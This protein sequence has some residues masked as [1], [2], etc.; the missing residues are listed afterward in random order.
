VRQ[1]IFFAAMV[2]ASLLGQAAEEGFATQR[3][4]EEIAKL[5]ELAA[6]GAV[7][8]ARLAQAE[9]MLADAQDEDTLQRLL[10]GQVRV[11]NLSQEQAREVVAA[12]A[13]RVDR[14]AARYRAQLALAEQGVIPK[15]Q[16]EEMEQQLADRRLTLQL[17]EGRAR[18]FADLM[19]M[20]KV[21]EE[22]AVNQEAD[23][24]PPPLIERFTGSGVFRNT[25]LDSV[26]A[27]FEKQFGRPLPV[28]ARGQSA[29]HTLLGFD[30][31]GR[32]DVALN[33]DEPEGQWLRQQLQALQVPYLALRAKIPGS[34]TAPH[35]HIGLPSQRVRAADTALGSG[36]N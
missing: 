7:S 13:R 3:A 27:G 26:A 20:A 17:A 21:E 25:H 16:V 1:S 23:I 10:Y 9:E 34:S 4:R 6:M 32:V 24:E 15:G 11:E 14:V 5:R 31:T 12:A 33:P 29:M 36:L 22:F 8:R 35:I 30:H 18:V 28:S 19:D 2:T